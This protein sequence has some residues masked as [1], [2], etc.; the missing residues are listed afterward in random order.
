MSSA[1]RGVGPPPVIRILHVD[2]DPAFGDLVKAFLERER[3]SF[4][5]ITEERAS[6]GLARLESDSIDCIVSDYNM[7]EQKGL[8]F[9]ELV[10]AS[11]PDMPFILFTGKGSEEIASEAISRG[12]TDY[13]Q[14]GGGADQYEV[15]GNRIQN[16]VQ[17]YRTEHELERSRAFLDTVLDLSP[18]AVVV[19]DGEGHI[20]RS[21]KLAET[22]LGLTKAEIATRTF[23][24]SEWEIVDENGQP[25]P[26]DA[27]PFKRVAET[28]EPV[29]DVEHGVRRPNGE[30]IWLSINAAPLKAETDQ[31]DQVVAVLSDESPR[32]IRERQQA[33]TIRQLEAMGRVLSHDMGNALNITQG[34]IALARDAADNEHLEKA[35][36][37]LH[38]ALDI[39]DDLT[40]AIQAGSVV[41]NIQT[42]PIAEVFER[43]WATQETK[44]ATKIVEP[45]IQIQADE[46][47][48][49]R[50]F[51]NLIR[52]SLEHGTETVS[53]RVGA[54]LNG[55][56]VEDD[57]PGIPTADRNRVFEPGNTSKANGMGIG[58][59]SIQQISLAHGWET[60]ITD[61][62][63]GGARFEFT[64]VNHH[65]STANS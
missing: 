48:L 14:K 7:P 8:E 38:R 11:Y 15:L 17:S 1:S 42:V 64:N 4:E 31:P 21:N 27:L 26:E 9:L 30:L 54:L 59:P 55:F 36:H 3:E 35:D 6:D 23:N 16:S 22:T 37:S 61:S 39:L 51:E 65:A 34:R 24:D 13:L 32:K 50:I 41:N 60:R 28:G 33:E 25:V 53:I 18:A 40:D 56:F 46:Q 10:R 58:L 49:L 57:G 47:A 44:A 29:Y 12:V 52:N 63:N 20:I 43:A 19:L 5:V 2:D 45:G 62:E